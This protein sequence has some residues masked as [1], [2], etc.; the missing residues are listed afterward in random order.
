MTSIPPIPDP[1][2]GAPTCPIGFTY[3]AA[4]NL[5]DSNSSAPVD[6][7]D[8]TIRKVVTGWADRNFDPAQASRLGMEGVKDSGIIER[9]V[10]AFLRGFVRLFRPLIEEAMSL[11]DDALSVLAETFLASQAQHSSG[12]YTLAAALMEDMLNVPV[13]G[14][15]LFNDFKSGGRVAAMQD[16]GGAVFDTL[17][18]EF[19]GA[20]QT[21]AGGLFVIKPGTGIGGLQ[22]KTLTPESGILGAKAFLGFMTA[23][24]VREGN[25]DLLADYI[26]HGFGRI[27]KD[28]AE[29]FAKNL[30]IGRMG[31]LVWKPLVTT[32][33]ATPLQWALN[34]EYRPTMLTIQ[35]AVR[36]FNNGD[37]TTE[38]LG[39]E[40]AR[41]GYNAK[42]AFALARQD[43]KNPT[44]NELRELFVQGKITDADR[45]VWLHNDKY[46]DA[47]I[48]TL[49]LAADWD[50]P[51]R[52]VRG[53][54]LRTAES[55]LGGKMTRAT[56]EGI[57][58]SLQHGTLG[59]VLLSPGEVTAL[60]SLPVI[61]VLGA[62]RHLSVMQNMR[63][64][65]DGIITLGEFETALTNLGYDAAAV[66]EETQEVLLMQKRL[67]DR[68]S[69]SA[70]SATRGPLWHLSVAQI[71]AGLAQ[72]LVTD[73]QIRAELSAR[74]YTAAA[75][76]DL[77]AEMY[78]KAKI[79]PPA[80]PTP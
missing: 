36:A 28:F 53:V 27:F 51:R 41:H 1:A 73:A 70:A 74:H 77:V 16:L 10:V 11:I 72:G 13:D 29:D 19:V 7:Q 37:Y 31:R 68:A 6:M 63:L 56:F 50:L 44:Y 39:E 46:A 5:C 33:V 65:L 59:N 35:E 32:T 49:D 26:P 12:Y 80:P 71:E 40:F 4:T 75:I 57:V 21:D 58:N 69:R 30:G 2:T 62:G 43:Q 66:M 76:N 9:A 61:G 54:A 18:S 24:A 78:A 60:L 8:P 45:R 34:E 67:S 64:Y 42:R 23:F 14:T 17:A 48:D 47:A 22:P 3:N 15:K 38:Q 25:T 55:Y 79:P 20:R 52:A